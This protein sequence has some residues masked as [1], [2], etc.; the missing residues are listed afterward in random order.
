MKQYFAALSKIAASA[1]LVAVAAPVMAQQAGDNIVTAGWFRLMP[2]DSSENLSVSGQPI[3]NTGANVNTTNTLG[4]T[5]DHFYTDN[6]GV[7]VDAG[8]P[9]KFQLNGEGILQG[10]HI[11]SARQWSPT[12]I[13][14]YYFGDK[15]SQVRP[16]VGLGV[17]YVWFTD[18]ELDSNF[19]QK[20]SGLISQGQS[21]AFPTAADLSKSLAPVF[22]AGVNYNIDKSWSVSLSLSYIPLKTSA[23]LNTNTPLGGVLS[24][25]TL[26]LD[27]I[28]SFVSLGYKF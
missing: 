26:T 7:T 4:M 12:V 5:F 6:F 27:P 17:T 22:N 28:V 23:N 14:K 8:I 15:N 9:P 13:A 18:I 2:Q 21:S 1:L 20:L 10:T 11:G 19:Q 16:F 25:T 24:S 3:P